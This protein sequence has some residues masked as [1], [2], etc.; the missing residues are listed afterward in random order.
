MTFICISII[1]KNP[2][3]YE[4]IKRSSSIL[5]FYY[6]K[7]LDFLPYIAYHRLNV[8]HVLHVE[9]VLQDIFFMKLPFIVKSVYKMEFLDLVLE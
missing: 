7:G 3:I 6:F 4:S 9:H 1:A 2:L 8:K 5:L